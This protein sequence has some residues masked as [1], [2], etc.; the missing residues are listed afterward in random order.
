MSGPHAPAANNGKPDSEELRR[1]ELAIID[2]IPPPIAADDERR[3][4]AADPKLGPALEK[5]AC[6]GACSAAAPCTN[7]LARRQY[8]ALALQ[9]ERFGRP[10]PPSDAA[11]Y[12]DSSGEFAPE[13]RGDAHEDPRDRLPRPSGNGKHAPAQAGPKQPPRVLDSYRPFPFDNLPP[14][15]D[16]FVRQAAIALGCDAAYVALPAL[17]VLASAIG[18]TRCV[19]LRRT[20]T[21]PSVIWTVNIGDSGTLKSP[22]WELAI[23]PVYHVQRRLKGEHDDA[24]AKY[25]RELAA[26]KEIERK[27][28]N[29]AGEAA[30][31]PAKPV[32][33]RVLCGDTTIEKLGE[34]LADNPRG[35]LVTQDELDGWLKSFHRYKGKQGSSDMPSWLQL[36]RAGALIVDRKT[37]DRPTLMVDRAAVSIAGGIQPG[38]LARALSQECL[39]AGLAGRLLMAMPPKM[40]K[41]WTDMEIEPKVQQEYQE[42][43]ERLLALDFD[44]GDDEP[45]PHALQLSADAKQVWVTFYNDWAQEQA[46]V[47]GELAAAFAKLEAYAARFALIHHVACRVFAYRDDRTAIESASVQAGITLCRWFADEARRVYSMLSE[48]DEQRDARRLVEFILSRGGRITTR[49]LQRSN[50]R[51]YRTADDAAA[52]LSGLIVAGMGEWIEPYRVLAL[53]MHD[54]RHPAPDA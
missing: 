16:E 54:A 4:L 21:E 34:L 5:V 49:D 8:L 11:G 26:H 32:L 45:A 22:A 9:R 37:G 6:W 52:A 41:R 1:M 44:H 10:I 48:T 12:S 50:N 28:K 19:R 24:L 14:P 27:A 39:E 47:E 33:Q 30:E 29:R 25:Q 42:V 40:P 13:Q 2:G 23:G 38:V 46:A 20:W 15:V 53:T 3:L 31:P 17:S 43:I 7:C 18:N 35:L 36:H 51:K